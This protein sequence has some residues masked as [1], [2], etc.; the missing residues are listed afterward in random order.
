MKGCNLRACILKTIFSKL[1]Q[2]LIYLSNIME[3]ALNSNGKPQNNRAIKAVF[4]QEFSRLRA[5]LWGQKST[6]FQEGKS[7]GILLCFRSFSLI[8]S[9][10][11]HNPPNKKS[12][13]L[14]VLSGATR[15]RSADDFTISFF[16]PQSFFA[17]R[18]SEL[19]DSGQLG[20]PK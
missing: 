7:V 2:Q 11:T 12:G 6:C 9:T 17:Q 1:L 14:N 18:L 3:N 13:T 15:L 20:K 19:S 5:G 4:W 10:R 8:F 16:V